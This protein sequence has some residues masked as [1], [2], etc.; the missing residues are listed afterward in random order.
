MCLDSRPVMSSGAG[1]GSLALAWLAVD[2]LL[3]SILRSSMGMRFICD[4][5]LR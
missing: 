4:H 5:P 1:D 2:V 3:D